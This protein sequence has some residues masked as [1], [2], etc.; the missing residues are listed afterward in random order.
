MCTTSFGKTN[1]ESQEVKERKAFVYDWLSLFDADVTKKWGTDLKEKRC[2]DMVK[3]FL[4]IVQEA[5]K[6]HQRLYKKFL[7]D[8]DD[9]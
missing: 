7:I 3:V 8:Q 2:A 1:L 5:D 9:A 6:F 4:P